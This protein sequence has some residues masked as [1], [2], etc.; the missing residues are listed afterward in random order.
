M[1][2]LIEKLITMIEKLIQ[3]LFD[4]MFDHADYVDN[5]TRARLMQMWWKEKQRRE[6]AE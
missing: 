4:W 1:K 6:D 3:T 5:E 2:T